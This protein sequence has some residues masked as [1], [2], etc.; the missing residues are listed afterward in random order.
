MRLLNRSFTY[1][2]DDRTGKSPLVVTYF[3]I[4]SIQQPENLKHFSVKTIG[5]FKYL[6]QLM[7]SWKFLPTK[8]KIMGII[9]IGSTFNEMID[10]VDFLRSSMHMSRYGGPF[11]PLEFDYM[12]RQSNNMWL[13]STI[14]RN[15]I[16]NYFWINFGLFPYQLIIFKSFNK[17]FILLIRKK[18]FINLAPLFSYLFLKE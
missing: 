7:A 2:S 15:Q 14:A 10:T 1:Q 8:K 16:R 13:R 6:I 12:L 18:K 3:E 11:T 5:L 9:V 17:P 4:P